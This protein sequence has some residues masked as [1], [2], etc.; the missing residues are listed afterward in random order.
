MITEERWRLISAE[1]HPPEPRGK[2]QGKRI[3]DQYSEGEVENMLN[4]EYNV[5]VGDPP[6]RVKYIR[7]N[8]CRR[9]DYCSGT[10]VQETK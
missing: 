3:D 7:R 8:F 4:P 10:T 6:R 1:Q 2:Y 5:R 9:G